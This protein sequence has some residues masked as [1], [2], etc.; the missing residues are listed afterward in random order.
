[1]RSLAPFF[2]L[3]CSRSTASNNSSPVNRLKNAGAS[4]LA[5][6]AEIMGHCRILALWVAFIWADSSCNGR[7]F[8]N[9]HLSRS[10]SACFINY[11][12]GLRLK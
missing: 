11:I 5:A 4:V 10:D 12:I 9:A 7:V 6:F 2:V 1:M 3:F 8:G